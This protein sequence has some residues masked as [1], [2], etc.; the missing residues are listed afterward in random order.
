MNKHLRDIAM[1]GALGILSLFASPVGAFATNYHYFTTIPDPFNSTL[2]SGPGNMYIRGINDSAQIV[3][4]ADANIIRSGFEGFLGSPSPYHSYAPGIFTGINDP[5]GCCSSGHS[6]TQI[7]GINNVGQM[8]GY[9]AASGGPGAFLYSGGKFT[10]VGSFGA[11]NAQGINDSGQIVGRLAP[12]VGGGGYLDT[13]GAFTHING[14]P[15]GINNQ[16]Q[17]VGTYGI[18]SGGGFLDRNNVYTPINDPLAS[19]GTT[20]PRGIN[21]EGQIVG[22][23][24][25]AAGVYNGFID[26]SGVFSTIND[27]LATGTMGTQLYGI[28]NNGQ[29]VG[30]YAHG[31]GF[32]ASTPEPGTVVLFGS[33]LLL[34]GLLLLRKR[35]TS[36]TV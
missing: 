29:I 35:E 5:S 21:N 31:I 12:S 23:Y 6:D 9:S 13:N 28:N 18:G 33:G 15:Y 32:I 4:F 20:V 14:D 22:Y 17:V 24:Q 2:T 3:G 36:S 30:D 25:N 8:V 26:N 7:S 10:G 1:A 16:G 11:Y 19:L 34:M 27:P